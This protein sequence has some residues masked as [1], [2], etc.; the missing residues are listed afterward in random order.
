M[1]G[2]AHSHM[3]GMGPKG[4]FAQYNVQTVLTKIKLREM[5]V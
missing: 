3:I 5:L 1:I 4:K 2:M